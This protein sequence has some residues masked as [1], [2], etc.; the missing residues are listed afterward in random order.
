MTKNNV[1]VAAGQTWKDINGKDYVV[2][3]T[4][5]D[6]HGHHWVHYRSNNKDSPMEYSCW[7]ESF[8]SRFTP[9]IN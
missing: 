4:Y 8:L 9:Y 7:A 6:E 1:S 3:H 5:L 2:L